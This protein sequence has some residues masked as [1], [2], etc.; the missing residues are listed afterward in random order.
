MLDG[1]KP[2]KSLG[3]TALHGRERDRMLDGMK[4]LEIAWGNFAGRER[5]RMLDG[6]KPW[7]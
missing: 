6:M 4:P 3:E 5:D 7:K 1:M 2:W